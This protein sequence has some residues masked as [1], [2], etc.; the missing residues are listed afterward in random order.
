MKKI[1]FVAAS[2][3]L[4]T[5][6]GGSNSTRSFNAITADLAGRANELQGLEGT[7]TND[8]P[9]SRSVN[10]SGAGRYVVTIFGSESDLA[11][12]VD[13]TVNF[14]R[15]TVTG[16]FTNFVDENNDQL[17]GSISLSSGVLDRGGREVLAEADLQ[18]NLV[19]PF[20]ENVEIDGALLG[21]FGDDDGTADVLAGLVGGD[22]TVDGIGGSFEGAFITEE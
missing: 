19:G 22:I 3:A 14:G 8:V 16:Q 15:D 17:S 1:Y 4:L 20:G 6:C 7:A 11:S 12:E 21:G 13:L 5:A 9:S 10:F 18:G 2:L